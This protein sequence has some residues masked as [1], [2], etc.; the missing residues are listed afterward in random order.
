[1]RL[2]ASIVPQG[3]LL[4]TRVRPEDLSMGVNLTCILQLSFTC[5]EAWTASELSRVGL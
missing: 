5:D 1:M 4:E 2:E 3:T